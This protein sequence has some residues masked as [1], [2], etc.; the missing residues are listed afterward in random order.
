A[1]AEHPAVFALS[2]VNEV[3]PDI[4][5]WSGAS[6]VADFIDE[7]IGVVKAINPESLC[8]FGNYPP[9]EFLRPCEIDFHCFNVYLHDQR[10]FD[11]Y[12]ARLQMIAD[13]KPLILGE[14]GIDSLREGELRQ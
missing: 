2:V 4:V 9:T 5:R 7:L 13:T 3:P 1:C 14:F 12:L 10:P 6:H 11:N 8:T